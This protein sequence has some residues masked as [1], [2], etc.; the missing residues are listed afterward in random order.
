MNSY[1]RLLEIIELR[2]GTDPKIKLTKKLSPEDQA[3]AVRMKAAK[4]NVMRARDE[5]AAKQGYRRIK[6]TK[7][8]A[9]RRAQ[10]Y[11]WVGSKQATILSHSEMNSYERIY[12]MLVE[13]YTSPADRMRGPRGVKSAK[14][15]ASEGKPRVVSPDPAVEAAHR[16]RNLTR[17][18]LGSMRARTGG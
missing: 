8:A 17:A 7:G 12:N 9:R 1:E 2:K 18:L 11:P 16:R 15:Q 10:K 4:I 14:I 13:Q 5:A 6:G 3:A